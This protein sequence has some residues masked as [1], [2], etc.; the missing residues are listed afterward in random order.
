MMAVP[1][2]VR[3]SC[4]GCHLMLSLTSSASWTQ[5]RSVCVYV[6]VCNLVQKDAPQSRSHRKTGKK[7]D[8]YYLIP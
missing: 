6:H 4:H 2:T 1:T 5:V 8:D 7:E 3:I